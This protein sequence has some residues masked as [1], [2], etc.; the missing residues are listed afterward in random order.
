M[1]GICALV[2]RSKKVLAIRHAVVRRPL[3][4]ESIVKSAQVYELLP[5]LVYWKAR[6]TEQEDADAPLEIFSF[7]PY[8]KNRSR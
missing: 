2:L 5:S 6:Y 1:V 8:F 4:T 3:V 7:A